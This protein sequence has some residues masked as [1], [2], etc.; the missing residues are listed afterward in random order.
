MQSLWL[1]RIPFEAA[2]DHQSRVLTRLLQGGEG[3]ILGFESE[4]VITLGLRSTREDLLFPPGSIRARG[5][6]TLQLD[7]GG[8]AT[9]H[10]PGQ[11]V[12]FPVMPIGPHGVKAWIERLAETTRRSAGHFDKNIEWNPACPGLYSTGGKVASIGVRVR[13]G[14]STHGVSVM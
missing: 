12:I 5:Y 8:Q 14:L 4:P 3:A 10:N 1:G 7:R 9:L 6:A 11:L 13:Q 2:L